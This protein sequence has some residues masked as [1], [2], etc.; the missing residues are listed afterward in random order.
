MCVQHTTSARMEAGSSL[1][2]LLNA[3]VSCSAMPRARVCVCV[4]VGVCRA[5]SK[6]V[7]TKDHAFVLHV[8]AAGCTNLWALL[9]F[10]LRSQGVSVLACMCVLTSACALQWH[11][12]VCVTQVL[13]TPALLQ[14]TGGKGVALGGAHAA[15]P[16]SSCSC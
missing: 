12:C 4:C 10:A 3:D 9:P 16:A 1:C 2:R 6:G 11:V 5:V 13:E 8:H 7:C 15:A 14:G